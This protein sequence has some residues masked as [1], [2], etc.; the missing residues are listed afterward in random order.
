M[1]IT[2]ATLQNVIDGEHV[3]PS[4]ET[5]AILNPATGEE[6]TRAPLSSAKDVD[7]AVRAARTAFEE[8]SRTTP[9]VR[10]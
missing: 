3:P 10:A 8:W 1:A 6:L 7:Q 9:A 4:G 5:E 2:A